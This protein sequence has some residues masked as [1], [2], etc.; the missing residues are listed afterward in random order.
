LRGFV[1]AWRFGVPEAMSKPP[2][3]GFT[4][5]PGGGLDFLEK[6]REITKDDGGSSMKR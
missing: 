1:L 2:S 3:I 5:Q 6:H 4:V